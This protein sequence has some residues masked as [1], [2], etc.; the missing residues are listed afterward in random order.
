MAAA[1]GKARRHLRRPRRAAACPT[2]PLPGEHLRRGQLCARPTGVLVCPARPRRGTHQGPTR[3]EAASCP[4][5]HAPY[6]P[7]SSSG[8]AHAGGPSLLPAVPSAAGRMGVQADAR[9]RA[10]PL[11]R[12]VGLPGHTPF[13]LTPSTCHAAVR[14]G[15]DP[16][17]SSRGP[18]SPHPRQQVLL[19][20][21]KN[22][23]RPSVCKAVT[24]HADLHF[25]N[26]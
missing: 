11:S 19:P 15:C 25:H 22:D 23:K 5:V 17:I 26:D 16:T 2:S 13:C 18:I 1:L 9:A 4:A 12:A 6:S 7:P 24:F 20:T 21:F 10:E 3:S 8:G 14:S